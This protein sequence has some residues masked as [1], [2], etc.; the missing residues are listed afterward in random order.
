MTDHTPTPRPGPAT[1]TRIDNRGAGVND[2][3]IEMRSRLMFGLLDRG[4]KDLE[5]ILTLTDRMELG[6][7]FDAE[8]DD[9]DEGDD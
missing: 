3:Q 5:T 8:D 9:S 4:I 1:P 6:P 7:D 2:D